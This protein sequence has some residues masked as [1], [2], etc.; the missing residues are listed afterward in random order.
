[1][2][3]EFTVIEEV[4]SCGSVSCLINTEP[5][6]LLRL[7]P[8]EPMASESVGLVLGGYIQTNFPAIVSEL[9]FMRAGGKGVSPGNLSLLFLIVKAVALVLFR[10]Q[11][12]A[13]P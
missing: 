2:L 10:F 13:P 9:I 6:E 3:A 12:V 8:S 11:D 1:M 7:Q 4:S 5:L